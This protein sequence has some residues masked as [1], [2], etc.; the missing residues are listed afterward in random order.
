MMQLGHAHMR[1]VRVLSHC[2]LSSRG[3]ITLGF[4]ELRFSQALSGFRTF[5]TSAPPFL[6][7]ILRKDQPSGL[8]D[9]VKIQSTSWDAEHRVYD[10]GLTLASRMIRA[11]AGPLIP[12]TIARLPS[13]PSAGE[14]TPTMRATYTNAAPFEHRHSLCDSS[15]Y[16]RGSPLRGFKAA[17]WTDLLTRGTHIQG[18]GAM[19]SPSVESHL[20]RMLS[21]RQLQYH[22]LV[23]PF[24]D[25]CVPT[26]ANECGFTT[27]SGRV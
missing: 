12:Q 13:K 20:N 7:H 24:D 9:P 3:L 1:S 21:E 16:G 27:L 18:T 4:S 17:G 6:I 8:L 10:R 23:T 22:S 5:I 14:L 26:D 19:Y 25:E 11:N 15:S 2:F